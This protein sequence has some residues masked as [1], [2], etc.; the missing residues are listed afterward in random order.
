M[1]VQSKSN[2][3]WNMVAL[4]EENPWLSDLD[5]EAANECLAGRRHLFDQLRQHGEFWSLSQ[6][7]REA[8][9]PEVRELRWIPLDE[10]VFLTLST[11]VAGNVHFVNEWQAAEFARLGIK[12]RDPMFMTAC[13]LMEVAAFPDVPS[14]VS[15]CTERMGDRAGMQAERERIQW[16]FAGMTDADVRAGGRNSAGEP[17]E[18]VKDARTILQLREERA[19]ESRSAAAKL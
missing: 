17:D 19:L 6:A 11:M 15:H 14:L 3:M 16:L 13:A 1:P 7:E 12:R 18:M 2:I 4:A 8:V 10:A 5:V 9:A